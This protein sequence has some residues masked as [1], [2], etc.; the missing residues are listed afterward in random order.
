M[1]KHI[2]AQRPSAICEGCGKYIAGRDQFFTDKGE[3]L[4]LSCYDQWYDAT[5]C[6]ECGYF[7]DECK[8][9]KDIEPEP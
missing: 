6:E 1:V 8:C 4:C 3:V 2:A 7:W 5:H 9:A